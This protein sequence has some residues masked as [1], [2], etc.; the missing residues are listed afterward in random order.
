MKAVYCQ[1]MPRITVNHA[2]KE[3]RRASGAGAL[4]DNKHRLITYFGCF[5][6]RFTLPEG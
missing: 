4:L 2:L 3:E 6:A 5:S 1:Y